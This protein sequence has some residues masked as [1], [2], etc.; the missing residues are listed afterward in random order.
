MQRNTGI[1]VLKNSTIPAALIECGYMS[2]ANDIAALKDD[3]KIELM[4]KNIL[5][6]VAMYANNKVDKSSL[7]QIQKENADTNAPG[8][9]MR[10]DTAVPLY[11]LDGKVVDKSVVDKK[12]P[13]SIKSINV[14]K[15]KS[16]KDKY[17]E[18]GKN[19]VLEITLKKEIPPPPPPP[20]PEEPST[21]PNPPT[22]DTLG[23]STETK[24][25]L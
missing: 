23:G 13:S 21:P 2:N 8:Q 5:Q 4:A 19:G 6:G 15:G 1:W 20:L 7:Y 24:L 12:D 16:A 18:K 11:V 9:T 14:L 3:A 25:A 22:K 17:G 10:R